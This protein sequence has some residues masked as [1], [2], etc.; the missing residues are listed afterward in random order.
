MVKDGQIRPMTSFLK[1]NTEG[2]LVGAEVGVWEGMNAKNILENLNIK[3]LYLVD[4]WKR[5]RIYTGRLFGQEAMNR[6]Y[7]LTMNRVKPWFDKIEV[8]RQK[9]VQGSHY[10]QN[11]SL[12]F[13]YID[14]RHI[15]RCLKQDIK[16]WLPK[17]KKGG[18][19]GGHDYYS[20]T[21]GVITA[22]D[23]MVKKHGFKLHQEDMDWWIKNE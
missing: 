21:P 11:G 6:R 10:V 16:F 8:I 22:V 15:Y 5:Y 4:P 3:L 19:L 18:Y 9:S 13:C 1:K 7:Q 23:Q 12:D 20:A 2:P 17:I 14:G